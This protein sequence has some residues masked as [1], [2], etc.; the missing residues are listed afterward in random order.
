MIVPRLRHRIDD[1]AL[2]PLALARR[3][4][5]RIPAIALHQAPFIEFDDVAAR[6]GHTD[7][8]IGRIEVFV[9]EVAVGWAQNDRAWILVRL[10][11]REGQ[12]EWHQ[13]KCVIGMNRLTAF[14]AIGK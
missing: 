1:Q 2:V 8:Q 14:G 4:G 12:P 11:K 13:F 5:R 9:E 6:C 3:S 7:V 10:H